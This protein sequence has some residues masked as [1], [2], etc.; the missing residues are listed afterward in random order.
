MSPNRSSGQ[1]SSGIVEK[2]FTIMNRLG[3]HARPASVLARLTAQFDCEIFIQ[4]GKTEING[5]SI[6]G[7]I[8]LAASQGVVLRFKAIGPDAGEA[9]DAIGELI[10]SKFGED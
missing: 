4:R 7:I 9:I 10:N 8:T 3:M 2:D 1:N 5:K 6:M